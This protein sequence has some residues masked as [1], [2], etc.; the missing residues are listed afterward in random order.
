MFI[1]PPARVELTMTPDHTWDKR[2]LKVTPASGLKP[3]I[4]KHPYWTTD[5]AHHIHIVWTT[6]FSGLTMDLEER[7]SNLVGTA[8]TF[9]DFDRQRQTSEVVATRISCHGKK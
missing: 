6:G 4:H 3:S 8:H 5:D 9:W 2:G 7:G 1:S